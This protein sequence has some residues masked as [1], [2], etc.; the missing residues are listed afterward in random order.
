MIGNTQFH[1]SSVEHIH[2]SL[3]EDREQLAQ[4]NHALRAIVA[5]LLVKNQNLRWALL[6]QGSALLAHEPRV[7][8]TSGGTPLRR[9]ARTAGTP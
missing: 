5:E 6:G 8:M 9:N 1:P 7:L 4:E 2:G 3:N